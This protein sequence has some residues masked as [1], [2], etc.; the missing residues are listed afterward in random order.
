MDH[1][2]WYK[3]LE[4]YLLESNREVSSVFC[5]RHIQPFLAEWRNQSFITPAFLAS[6]DKLINHSQSDKLPICCNSIP[7]H[8]NEFYEASGVGVVSLCRICNRMRLGTKYR[9]VDRNFVIRLISH[10]CFNCLVH[11]SYDLLSQQ[12]LNKSEQK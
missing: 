5:R 10:I 3:Q 12:H 4:T 2:S 7:V 11:R 8:L 9:T 1:L 6:L